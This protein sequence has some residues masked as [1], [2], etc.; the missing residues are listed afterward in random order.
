MSKKMIDYFSN[1]RMN[2]DVKEYETYL[3]EVRESSV[4]LE[5]YKQLF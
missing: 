1:K 3:K 5:W 2:L 4:L